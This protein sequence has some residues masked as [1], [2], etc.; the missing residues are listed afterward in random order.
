M[1]LHGVFMEV[2]NGAG[3][4]FAPRKHTVSVPP[5]ETVEAHLTFDEAGPWALHCHLLYHMMTGM[6][7]RVE[8]ADRVTEEER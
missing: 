7:A 6:F 1:H 4:R 2:Q 3:R 5:N 8:V